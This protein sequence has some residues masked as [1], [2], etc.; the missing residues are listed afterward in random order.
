MKK[1][2]N[3][4]AVPG[5]LSLD[6]SFEMIS[7][8]GFDGVELNMDE[9]KRGDGKI[10]LH[11]NCGESELKAIK[12]TAEKYNLKIINYL[13]IKNNKK[14]KNNRRSRNFSR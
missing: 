3:I 10:S 2:I 14:L 1:G 11:Y 12:E 13:E 5:N 6:E 7:R 4:Y 9:N 8:A